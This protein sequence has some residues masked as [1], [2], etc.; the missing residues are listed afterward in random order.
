MNTVE[1]KGIREYS[2]TKKDGTIKEM[3]CINDTIHLSKEQLKACGYS[4]PRA[5]IGNKMNVTFYQEN[6]LL[7]D[8]VTKCTKADTIVKSF[9]IEQSVLDIQFAKLANAG[10]SVKL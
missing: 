3:V 2:R 8:K 10:L 9:D 6:E 5:I 7:I 1:I 4:N